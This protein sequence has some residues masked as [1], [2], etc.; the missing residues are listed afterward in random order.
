M[1]HFGDYAWSCYKAGHAEALRIAKDG[2]D[3]EKHGDSTDLKDYYDKPIRDAN[4]KPKNLFKDKD[5]K[6]VNLSKEDSLKLAYFYDAFALHYLSDQFASGHTRS[7]RMEMNKPLEL[8]KAGSIGLFASVADVITVRLLTMANT[9]SGL[10]KFSKLRPC[11][12][13]WDGMT[14]F[15]HDLDGTT[16]LRVHNKR[17][18]QWIAYGD[19]QYFLEPN[20]IN[21]LKRLV[22]L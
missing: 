8:G 7:P 3:I 20:R 22:Y 4:G 13:G 2:V 17:G 14:G 5:G 1:D 6:P 21:R 19:A 18:D 10:F 16:G 12:G 9:V 15:L 11:R